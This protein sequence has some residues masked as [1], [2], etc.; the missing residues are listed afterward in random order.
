[1]KNN[2]FAIFLLMG[3]LALS[4]ILALFAPRILQKKN[5]PAQHA[6]TKQMFITAKGSVES[7]ERLMQAVRSPL[8]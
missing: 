5:A 1:M 3:L 7:E 8:Q 4:L 6:E 2:R